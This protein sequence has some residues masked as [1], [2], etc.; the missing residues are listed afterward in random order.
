VTNVHSNQA[1]N[2]S[3]NI[4]IPLQQSSV[5]RFQAALEAQGGNNSSDEDNNGSGD[6]DRS[7][8]Y[9]GS[10]EKSKFKS[11]GNFSGAFSLFRESLELGFPQDESQAGLIEELLDA[12]GNGLEAGKCL[13]GDDWRFMIRLEPQLLPMTS[14]EMSCLHDCVGAVLRTSDENSYRTIV[15]ALPRLNSL[16]MHQ[17][18]GNDCASVFL[19][20]AEDFL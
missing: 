17:Q 8:Q 7:Q 19:V 9:A 11:G 4:E 15:N 14:L 6:E 3:R 5:F 16:L 20:N 2:G 10:K 13:K 1:L 12:V 18:L